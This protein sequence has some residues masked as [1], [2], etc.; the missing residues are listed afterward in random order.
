MIFTKKYLA[1]LSALTLV[2]NSFASDFASYDEYKFKS[3]DTY[4]P[5]K[6]IKGKT[7]L[8]KWKEKRNK[9]VQKC[10][11]M[12]CY[13]NIIDC[14]DI[15]CF[16]FNTKSK[17]PTYIRGQKNPKKYLDLKK[18]YR[19]KDALF[20]Q[21]G[22]E[23]E[24]KKQVYSY[25]DDIFFKDTLKKSANNSLRQTH[26]NGS[27]N[28]IGTQDFDF[29]DPFDVPEVKEDLKSTYRNP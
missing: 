9:N 26:I 14:E 21:D 12:D 19:E 29:K 20:G 5:S 28:T 22:N 4:K 8:K 11:G 13:D 24:V 3:E 1:I 2:G 18:E 27:S 15:D 16:D 7:D 17:S 25:D 23:T 10:K 6:M